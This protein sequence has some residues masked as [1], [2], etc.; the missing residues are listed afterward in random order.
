MTANNDNLPFSKRYG[1]EPVELPFQVDNINDALR[2]DLW[3]SFYLFIHS[4]LEEYGYGKSQHRRIYQLAWLY[5]FRKPFDDFPNQDYELADLVR[6][7]IEKGLWYKVYEFFEFVFNHVERSDIYNIE[8]FIKYVD[9]TLQINHSG[10]RLVDKKFIPV[11]NETEIT[12]IEQVKD[13]AT[14]F[15]L[16][17]IQ[18]HLNSALEL[19]SKKPKP[20]LKNVIKESISMVEVISRLIEPTENTLG[21]ALNKLETN[22]K[23]NPTLKLAFEKLYAYTNGKN[24]IR[25]ALMENENISIEDARFFLIACSAFTNYLIGKANNEKLLNSV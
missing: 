5:F 2:I 1:Y 7:H 17:G 4:P 6:K 23:I 14:E 9:D 16:F 11:T 21:K 15:G 24:G 12:E 20:D 8:G 13:S 25:H 22:Q 18:E 19:I 10:F 3:N